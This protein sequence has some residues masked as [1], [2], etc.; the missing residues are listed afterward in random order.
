M[1]GSEIVSRD[2]MAQICADARDA[3][4]GIPAI[5]GP[6]SANTCS[7]VAGPK[8]FRPPLLLP[9]RGASEQQLGRSKQ[10]R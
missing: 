4:M 3:R 8:C 2:A 7:F 6:A 1:D 10:R 5:N 9:Q